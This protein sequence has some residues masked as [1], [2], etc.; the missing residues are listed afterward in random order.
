MR[1]VWTILHYTIGMES[2]IYDEIYI[3]VCN[4]NNN[5]SEI[6]LYAQGI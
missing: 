6:D 5:T 3:M 1:Y 4:N 2:K